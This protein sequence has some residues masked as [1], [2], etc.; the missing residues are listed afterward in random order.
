MIVTAILFDKFSHT[1]FNTA[2]HTLCVKSH[3]RYLVE[4]R[5][6]PFARRQI[7]CGYQRTFPPFTPY[8]GTDLGHLEKQMLSS[9]TNFFLS[10][11]RLLFGD[12][13][14]FV[15]RAVDWVNQ[16]L[17]LFIQWIKELHIVVCNALKIAADAVSSWISTATAVVAV[18]IR[19]A[20]TS[21]SRFKEMFTFSSFFSRKDPT[22]DE[23]I[24]LSFM[25]SQEKDEITDCLTPQSNHSEG[26]SKYVT[27]EWWAKLIDRI[28][29]AISGP[30]QQLGSVSFNRGCCP[31]FRTYAST[32]VLMGGVCRV[33]RELGVTDIV[34]Q[35]FDYVYMKTTGN[36]PLFNYTMLKT[37]KLLCVELDDLLSIYNKSPNPTR[38]VTVR[39]SH[40]FKELETMYP[41][42]ISECKRD[43]GHYTAIFRHYEKLCNQAVTC[44]KTSKRIKPVVVVLRGPAG[45]GKTSAVDA[46][47]RDVM[48]N[49]ARAI[50]P[51]DEQ[52]ANTYFADHSCAPSSFTVNAL[53]KTPE[54]DDGYCDPVWYNINEYLT[55]KDSEAKVS[56]ATKFFQVIGAEPYLL[57]MAFGDKGKKFFNS[58]FVTA[59][60]NFDQHHTAFE[61]PTAYFRRIEFDLKA[62]AT[63][64]VDPVTK[65]P[66]PFDL[67]E[68]VTFTPSNEMIAVI[69]GDCCPSPVLKT[70]FWDS[71]VSGTKIEFGY[72]DLLSMVT[73]V[74][75]ER[76]TAHAMAAA[77]ETKVVLIDDEVAVRGFNRGDAFPDTAP[78]HYVK[79]HVRGEVLEKDRETNVRLSTCVLSN[80]PDCSES[81]ISRIMSRVGEKFRNDIKDQTQQTA[82]AMKEAASKQVVNEWHVAGQP[83]GDAWASNNDNPVCAQAT[84][85][86]CSLGPDRDLPDL[87][88][89]FPQVF[90]DFS[91]KPKDDPNVDPW[92]AE[93]DDLM[94]H[95]FPSFKELV[96]RRL[97]LAVTDPNDLAP[98]LFRWIPKR[99]RSDIVP[100]GDFPTSVHKLC[101]NSKPYE[102]YYDIARRLPAFRRLAGEGSEMIFNKD[103]LQG[104]LRRDI[105]SAI[106]FLNKS[107]GY[108]I[109]FGLALR[110]ALKKNGSVPWDQSRPHPVALAQVKK[111]NPSCLAVWKGVVWDKYK[112]PTNADGTLSQFSD[113]AKKRYLARQ[114]A[115]KRRHELQNAKKNA[116][117]D[118]KRAEAKA[119]TSR[120]VTRDMIDGSRRRDKKPR[121]EFKD[122][123]FEKQ[124]NSGDDDFQKVSSDLAAVRPKLL[125]AVTSCAA[126]FDSLFPNYI[127]D[128]ILNTLSNGKKEAYVKPWKCRVAPLLYKYD[129]AY[130]FYPVDPEQPPDGCYL[131]AGK[132]KSSAFFEDVFVREVISVTHSLLQA[133]FRDFDGEVSFAPDEIFTQIKFYKCFLHVI[134]SDFSVLPRPIFA[135]KL[136]SFFHAVT[137]HLPPL[138]ERKRGHPGR[139]QMGRYLYSMAVLCTR[140]A[141]PTYFDSYDTVAK[142]LFDEQA[143]VSAHSLNLLEDDVADV[144]NDILS[145]LLRWLDTTDSALGSVAIR[146]PAFLCYVRRPWREPRTYGLILGLIVN[147]LVT[148]AALAGFILLVKK[149]VSL[150]RGSSGDTPTPETDVDEIKSAI[151]TLN[152]AGIAVGGPSTSVEAQRYDPKGDKAEPKPKPQFTKIK[153]RVNKQSL[154]VRSPVPAKVERNSYA[155]FDVVTHDRLASLVFVAG[156]FALINKHVWEALPSY[157]HLVSHDW[158]RN[159]RVI[160]MVTKTSCTPID[161]F[162]SDSKSMLVEIATR[163]QH[164]KIIS[165]FWSKEEAHKLQGHVVSASLL[166][167]DTELEGQAGAGNVAHLSNC[168]QTSKKV[169]VYDKGASCHD[170]Y[171]AEPV[172]YQWNNNAPGI[173]GSAVMGEVN[174]SWKVMALHEA[175]SQK[176]GMCVGDTVYYE[177]LKIIEDPGFRSTYI[178]KLGSTAFVSLEDEDPMVKQ[179]CHWDDEKGGW[180]GA[181]K[182]KPSDTTTF[183]AT[184][185]IEPE[186]KL[187]VDCAPADTS[188]EAYHKAR[189]KEETAGSVV[190]Q[191]SFVADLA[192]EYAPLIVDC[193]LEGNPLVRNC[194]V[195]GI[196]ETLERQ[197]L[198]PFD[199]T[200]SN[201]PRLTHLGLKKEDFL[202]RVSPTFEIVSD[203]I[204]GYIESMRQGRFPRQIG[205]DK[206]KDEI[207]DG[208]RVRAK[209]TRIFNVIDFMD[210]FMQKMILGDLVAAT[211]T[212]FVYGMSSCGID[213]RSMLWTRIYDT[214]KDEEVIFADISGF[215]Y[216]HRFWIMYVVD[217]LI[218]RS[219]PDLEDRVLASW[220]VSSCMTAVR[221]CGHTGRC[222]YR[223]NSSGN[224]IT[225]WFNTINNY[226]YFSLCVISLA[227]KYGDDPVQCMRELKIKLYSDDNLSSLRRPWYTPENVYTFFKTVLHIEL[228]GVDKGPMTRE[229][230]CGRI[231]EAEFL[232]RGIV[233]RG[234]FAYAPLDRNKLMHQLH[235]VRLPR[236]AGFQMLCSQLQQNLDNVVSELAEYDRDTA[237]EIYSELKRLVM[238][239]ENRRFALTLPEPPEVDHVKSVRYL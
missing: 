219:Y 211:D 94:A 135:L 143:R 88:D 229:N 63:R 125:E 154:G 17:D 156:H 216:T 128:I 176:S 102:V 179:F 217:E 75:L 195:K 234:A 1:A 218:R 151:K 236:Y 116:I 47:V 24:D 208:D 68:D 5:A 6:N 73:A 147:V 133:S 168:F 28:V 78:V 33:S 228:T 204:N 50:G 177:D 224:W 3:V 124:F 189:A 80:L 66:L 74:Y 12:S 91:P 196:V 35:A 134:A 107:V 203:H 212:I 84:S 77:Q 55:P 112:I 174:G 57:N 233:K 198:N 21:V 105:V 214:F 194:S 205:F 122:M 60:G 136:K 190:N 59:T 186:S 123:R 104:R 163:H 139:A 171:L 126:E 155:I 129:P 48:P 38:R 92:F 215:D 213:P 61:D 14:G 2:L 235:Y 170:Y 113:E 93:V 118:A 121:R 53:S 226:A 120:K 207:R 64:R 79:K 209:K 71:I 140:G 220:A 137:E 22:P 109:G 15:E 221:F 160:E 110:K 89:L 201:G 192:K 49:V 238:S 62:S 25:E 145:P 106:R 178:N 39:I 131:D 10:V 44:L 237:L 130:P 29:E 111:L 42:I 46:L 30:F 127:S 99:M 165:S 101:S 231:T 227:K 184:G 167:W 117:R 193:M 100:H 108:V 54:Y 58:P 96:N 166:Y 230:S 206:L 67:L 183:R 8:S 150:V 97:D 31:D 98:Q 52:Y 82:D 45:C 182:V 188:M 152:G 32:I 70:A 36:P 9:T 7:K 161:C 225:T 173:C 153:E 138:I 26:C 172:V 18:M 40:K 222:I 162:H 200:T 169:A 175:G 199:K 41:L 185:F 85:H 65:T 223:G 34:K 142:L 149:I 159:K 86:A 115:N 56:W 69:S 37:W 148:G 87:D 23:I 119:M 51:M 197:D 181:N 144:F 13:R 239:K 72:R 210:N 114:K 187:F 83:D 43:T 11:R 90:R 141:I 191:M 232:S 146:V 76:I 4:R 95:V 20:Q 81:I 132:N 202:N 158:T 157:F 103:S 164:P 19:R 180:F 27:Q 16:G